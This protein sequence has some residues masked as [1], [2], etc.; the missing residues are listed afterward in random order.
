MS[1]EESAKGGAR[2]DRAV[3]KP[4]E[5]PLRALEGLVEKG[6]TD[7]GEEIGGLRRAAERELERGAKKLRGLPEPLEGMT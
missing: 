1:E 5:D 2:G 6:T 4:M 7:V 3:P